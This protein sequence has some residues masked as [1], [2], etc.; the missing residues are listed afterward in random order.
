MK[1]FFPFVRALV[2]TTLRCRP[3]SQN[4]VIVTTSADSAKIVAMS[5]SILVNKLANVV[6]AI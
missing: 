3:V 5:V 6:A 2:A 1:I 4:T